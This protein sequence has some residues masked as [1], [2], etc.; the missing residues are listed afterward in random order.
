[1]KRE[2]IRISPEEFQYWKQLPT[3][4]WFLKEVIQIK[5]DRETWNNEGQFFDNPNRDAEHCKSIGVI[6]ALNDVL[7]LIPKNE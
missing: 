7:Q 6:E 1:M 3:T 5:R 2:Q 4:Q